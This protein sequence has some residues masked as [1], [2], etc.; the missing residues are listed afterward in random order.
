MSRMAVGKS[1]ER[2]A[3]ASNFAL[4]GT[5]LILELFLP[6]VSTSIFSTFDCVD[7]DNGP[8]LRADLKISCDEET[9]DRSF[10]V[11]YAY[12]MA[13]VYPIG[14]PQLLDDGHGRPVVT[15]SCSA[16]AMVIVRQEVVHLR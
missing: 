6:S 15:A 10:W 13:L 12:L 2:V 4:R 7:F 16:T 5:L 8:F 3:Q 1:D 14:A 9:T 11:S